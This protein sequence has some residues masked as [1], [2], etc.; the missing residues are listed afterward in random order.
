MVD[1]YTQ[2]EWT[3]ERNKVD[4]IES[5][6]KRRRESKNS[7]N[8]KGKKKMEKYILKRMIHGKHHAECGMD[9]VY[10]D[11]FAINHTSTFIYFSSLLL[12]F[13]FILSTPHYFS[14]IFI[15]SF[16]FSI[17]IC[18]FDAT[19][20]TTLVRRPVKRNKEKVR[21][22]RN[23]LKMCQHKMKKK[24]NNRKFWNRISS[25]VLRVFHSKWWHVTL[26]LIA[27]FSSSFCHFHFH[28]DLVS[29]HFYFVVWFV[30]EFPDFFFRFENETII[31]R[32]RWK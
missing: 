22:T 14:L 1:S 32:I 10:L 8:R 6:A 5:E 26:A 29:F 17:C 4:E 16:L 18:V 28:F 20:M 13:V 3:T 2:N 12:S 15:R 21:W 19:T 27:F 7:S 9:Y 24:E 30:D 11:N 25:F 31:L 23:K